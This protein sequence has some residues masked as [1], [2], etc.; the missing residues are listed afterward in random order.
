R[1]TFK[2]VHYKAHEKK[3]PEVQFLMPLFNEQSRRSYLP[4]ENDL[5]I[6]HIQTKYGHHLFVYPFEGKFVHEGMA[7]VLAYRLSKIKESSFSIATNE[8]GIELLSDEPIPV[9]DEI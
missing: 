4:R 6:E 8:Y 2:E 7:A 9:T 1:H 5:L 3:S